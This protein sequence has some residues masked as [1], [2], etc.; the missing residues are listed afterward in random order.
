QSG[1][2]AGRE[3]DAKQIARAAGDAGEDDRAAVRRPGRVAHV[4]DPGKIQP[5]L[6]SAPLDVVDGDDTLAPREHAERDATAV[7]RP[8]DARVE[9]AEILEVRVRFGSHQ[10]LDDVAGRGIGEVELE[11]ERTRRQE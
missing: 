4:V 5:A 6:R 10:P 9:E 11:L 1:D 7:G 8:G 2:V 3:I